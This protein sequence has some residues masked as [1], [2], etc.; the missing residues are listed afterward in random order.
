MTPVTIPDIV[1]P[2]TQKLS[3]AAGPVYAIWFVVEAVRSSGTGNVIIG[4]AA[5]AV[6]HGI[7][8]QNSQPVTFPPQ[9]SDISDLYDLT[10][11]TAFLPTGW[12]LAITY[13]V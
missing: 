4:D 10:K 13:F 5:A 7:P 12:N 6:G 11:I 3:T 8:L 9:G 2:V 1:G